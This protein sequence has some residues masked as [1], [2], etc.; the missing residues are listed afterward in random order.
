[1]SRG[2]CRFETPLFLEPDWLVHEL[3]VDDDWVLAFSAD[4]PKSDSPSERTAT[5]S[6][7]MFQ[8]S[9]VLSASSFHDSNGCAALPMS[10]WT[11]YSCVSSWAIERAWAEL[12][13]PPLRI[14]NRVGAAMPS[15]CVNANTSGA[16]ELNEPLNV[17]PAIL[18][19]SVKA[20]FCLRAA[21][22]PASAV[23]H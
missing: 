18:T 2:N 22:G 17:G 16:R 1:M 14:K 6:R 3:T 21:A 23:A 13:K 11:L 15:K 19:G 20:N 7:Q 12:V 4:S 8:L 9:S 10:T 5:R